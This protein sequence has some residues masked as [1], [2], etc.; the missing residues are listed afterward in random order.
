MDGSGT[1]PLTLLLLVI[2]KHQYA[3]NLGH[4]HD[5]EHPYM[6]MIIT[7]YLQIVILNLLAFFA[8]NPL[9]TQNS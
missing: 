1:C 8:W 9:I 2:V 4:T 5:L 3:L 6:I 7:D